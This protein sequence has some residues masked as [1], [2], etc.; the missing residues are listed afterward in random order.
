M[1]PPESQLLSVAEAAKSL[2]VSRWRVN[3][4]IK[5]DALPAFKI[6]R[7]Y[8]IKLEDLDRVKVRPKGRPPKA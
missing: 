8:V 7:A 1:P 3:Q 5:A 2:G 4:M 6:G